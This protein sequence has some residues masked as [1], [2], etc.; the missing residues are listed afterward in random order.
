MYSVIKR[1][2][3]VRVE[4]TIELQAIGHINIASPQRSHRMTAS[5][6]GNGYLS[7][8]GFWQPDPVLKAK[9]PFAILLVRFE[10]EM[11]G[12]WF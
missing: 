10:R 12:C 11:T 9:A 4:S 7:L 8:T 2:N 5:G 1:P 3:T 6:W